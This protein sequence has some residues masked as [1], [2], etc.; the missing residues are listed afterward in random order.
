MLTKYTATLAPV[1]AA[2][3]LTASPASAATTVA[4]W[5]MN[6]KP[7]SDVMR[8]S[9][10]ASGNNNGQ[11]G[12]NVELLGG[13][14]RFP[15]ISRTAVDPGQL[16]TVAD[17]ALNPG[18]ADW[19]VTARMKFTKSYGNVLQ[20]GQGGTGNTYMKMQAP[21]GIVSCLFRGSAGSVSVNSGV[22][23]NDGAWHVVTCR[24]A[25]DAVTMTIDAGTAS[26]GTRRASGPTGSISNSMPFTIGGK[27]KCNGDTVSCDYW[28]GDMDYVKVSTG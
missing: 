13:V 6:E 17:S 12:D 26:A 25:G 7:G 3:L 1:L 16:V 8:D 19:S 20:K 28:V 23:L 18:T 15:Y 4:D 14:Y 2:V 11:I 5:Q 24:R 9:A 10:G 21:R 27:S 22:A